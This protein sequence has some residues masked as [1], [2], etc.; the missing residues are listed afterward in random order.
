MYGLI[1]KNQ[2]GHVLISSEFE[3]MHHAGMAEYVGVIKGT[4]TRFPDYFG[5]TSSQTFLAAD[6][7]QI[8][9]SFAQ[10]PED[11]QRVRYEYY[12]YAQG[13]AGSG[14]ESY[15]YN[16]YTAD[17][18]LTL[19][20]VDYISYIQA[21]QSFISSLPSQFSGR[22]IHRY[23]IQASTPPLFFVKPGL[24][25]EFHGVLQQFESAGFWYIDV[26]QGGLTSVPPIVHAF[27]LPSEIP[28]R[29]GG[30]GV[31]TYLANGRV[32][33]DS[34]L[35]PLIIHEAQ[36]VIPP[37][38]PCDG[39][40]PTQSGGYPWNDSI[41]DFDFHSNNTFNSYSMPATVDREHLMFSAPSVAQGVYSRIKNGYKRS[42]SLF[43]SQEHW[44]TAIWWAMYHSAYRLRDGAIDA[45]WAPYAAGYRFFSRWEGGGWFGGSGGSIDS[46]VQPYADKTINLQPNTIIVVDSR[47]YS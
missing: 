15:W 34:R 42:S 33:F 16:L 40:T 28:S 8:Q 24:V 37:Q 46:G 41:L 11:F 35:L 27:K 36:S 5:D 9:V 45:G 43:G 4:M 30:Y 20:S 17:E 1:T 23:R 26:I 2:Y 14:D 25:D 10:S 22:T 19:A 47:M 7:S 44:S 21:Q 3:S 18:A 32:A 12:L 39:G 6:G 29:S 31:A 38:R 13:Y